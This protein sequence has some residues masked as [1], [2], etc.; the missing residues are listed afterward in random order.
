MKLSG[1]IT[2]ARINYACLS[3]RF[4]VGQPRCL[5]G[6]VCFNNIHHLIIL[7]RVAWKKI[8]S[9][10]CHVS[11]TVYQIKGSNVIRNAI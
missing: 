11:R 4:V 3:A 8:L 9:A 1:N 7:F 5:P 2:H 6:V 10:S